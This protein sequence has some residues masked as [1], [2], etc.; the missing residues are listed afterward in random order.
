MGRRRGKFSHF[1]R[2]EKRRL[3]NIDDGGKWIVG[4]DYLLLFF[5][6]MFSAFMVTT[7]YSGISPAIVD[8]AVFQMM[9]GFGGMIFGLIM[10]I[11]RKGELGISVRPPTR[12]DIETA[13]PYVMGA[14]I[15]LVIVNRSLA[16]IG[17]ISVLLTGF[18]GDMNIALTA[19]V[20]EEAVFSFGF[21]TFFFK[22]F[23]YMT[24]NIMGRSKDQLYVAQGLAAIA[25]SILFFALHIAVYGTIFTVAAMLFINRFVYAIAYLRTRNLVVP[26]GLHLIHNF[27]CF[28]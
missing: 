10:S 27:M 1:S 28:F 17:L 2:Q 13:A 23:N 20:V 22:L 5:A 12:K 24:A 25:V 7:W 11:T 6:G 26:A 16:N 15:V 19:A 8:V 18:S 3:D 21:T 4:W 9:L 14:F